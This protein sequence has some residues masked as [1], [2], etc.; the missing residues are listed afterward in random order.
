MFEHDPPS[1]FRLPLDVFGGIE[2]RPTLRQHR[3]ESAQEADMITGIL[4][5]YE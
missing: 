2:Y 1:G 4:P 5:P 3:R